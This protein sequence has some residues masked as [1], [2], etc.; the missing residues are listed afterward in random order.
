VAVSAGAGNGS[1]F[2][3]LGAKVVEGGRTMNPST[4][5][6]VRALDELD[7]EEAV[8][9]PNSANVIMAAEQAAEN[10]SK[11]V[12]VVPTRSIQAGLAAV[13]AFDASRPAEQNA[14]VMGEAVAQ[15][16]TGGVTIASRDVQLDGVAVRKGAWLGLQ[17]GEPVVGGGSFEEV[18]EAVAERLLAEPRS[19]LTL[20]EGE[21]AQPLQ[22]LLERLAARHPD[23][24][25]E[26]HDGGQPN[27]ALLLSAE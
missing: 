21:H 20:L 12:A 26:V 15:V 18:A 16:A 1:L 23:V 24:E 8:L 14:S 13:V 17:D 5:D 10:V 27:Y 9:L 6:L 7:A 25:L 4:S 19:I 11:A 22:V 3:S 2:E